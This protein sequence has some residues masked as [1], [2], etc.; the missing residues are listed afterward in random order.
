MKDNIKTQNAKLKAQSSKRQRK[1]KSS[2]FDI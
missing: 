1:A 2:Y